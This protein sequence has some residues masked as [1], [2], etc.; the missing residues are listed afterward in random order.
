MGRR[1]VAAGCSNTHSDNISMHKFPKDPEVRQK[2][3]K[4]VQRTREKWSA[5]ESSFLCSNHFEADCFEVDSIL[6]E[7]M[8]L[9]RRKRL[10]PGAIPTIFVRCKQA[11]KQSAGAGQSSSDAP[12]SSARKRVSGAA[13]SVGTDYPPSKRMAFE[14]RERMRVSLFIDFM[15]M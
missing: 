15:Y 5:T 14:K 2:W 4:Q 9:K 1:C 7:Q 12:N 10:K 8:G 6:A 11:P 13:V 3:E